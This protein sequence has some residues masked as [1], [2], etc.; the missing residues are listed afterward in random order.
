MRFSYPIPKTDDDFEHLCCQLL[1]R[2][3]NRPQLQRYAHRGEEQDGVDIYDPLQTK[4]IRAAQCKLHD[5]GKTI[6]PKEI[7]EEVDKAKNHTPSIEHYT[8]LTTAKKSKQA[9]RKVAEINQL[10]QQEGLFTVEVL[11]WDQIEALLDQYPDVRDPIYNTVSG[12]TVTLF[13]QQFAALRVAIEVS[14]QPSSDAL[15]AELD[16][17]KAEV[18]RYEL[19]VAQRLAKR[20]EER[21][22][23]KLSPRQR[24][25]LL[26]LQASIFL[27]EGELERAGTLLLQA[28]QHQPQEE[29]AQVN[30]AL[31][32]EL[33]GDSERAHSLAITLRQ[34][35]PH[36]S[37]A[38]AVW[39]RTAPGTVGSA[40]LEAE[41]AQFAD[42]ECDVAL[43]LSI[44]SLNRGDV[45][46]AERHARRAT[47]L[48]PEVP[49]TWLMLG[50]S[51]HVRGFKEVRAEQRLQLLRQ[52]EAHYSKAVELAQAQGSAH[53]EAA[54]QLNRGIVRDL[55]GDSN[56]EEDFRAARRL[57]PQDASAMRKH[58]L[59]LANLGQMDQAVAEAR[60]ALT[61]EPDNESS[62][63]LA[64]MLWDRKQG[65]D[66]QQALDLC[67]K[68]ARGMGTARFDEALEMA[69][70]GLSE[71]KRWDEARVLLDSLAKGRVSE[72]ARNTFLAQLSLAQD[73]RAGAE[74][75][76]RVAHA[77]VGE[78]TGAADL[79]RLS[80]LL[81]RL[82]LYTLALPLLQ[83]ITQPGRFDSDTQ[84]LLDCANHLH[85]HRVILDVCRALR[86]AG[87]RD[88]RLLDNE[89]DI[90]QLYDR[91]AAI[92]VLLS[93]LA[94][95][96]D[97]RL[98][99]MRLSLLGLQSER[100]D[101]VT[102]DPDRLPRV[103]EAPPSTVGKAVI[104]LLQHTGH[105]S[106][107]LRYAYA[108]L[109]RNLSDPDA[110]LLYCNL[111]LL[112]EQD[113]LPI[114]SASTVQPGMAVAY[115]EKGDSQ[116]HW[117]VLEE[118]EHDLLHDELSPNHARVQQML[119]KRPGDT[120]SLSM[121]GIQ[122]RTAE[123]VAILSKY[124]Y[125]F[126]DSMNQFQVRFPTREDLQQVRLATEGSE[127]N[128]QLDPTPI[129]ASLDRRRERVQQAL[130]VFHRQPTPVHLLA[131]SVGRHIF[132][133][134]NSLTRNPNAGVRWCCLGNVN[135][136]EEALGALRD[137]RSVVLD[138]TAL[139]T[140]W[141]LNLFDLLRRWG[142]R[143]FCVSQTTLDKVRD[144]IE[145]ETRPGTRRQIATDDHGRYVF[146]EVPD[147]AL[148][149][150]VEAHQRLGAFIRE[151]CMLPVPELA[152]LDP[153]RR[154]QLVELFDRDGLESITLAARDGH[155]LWTD[156]LTLAVIAREDFGSPRRAWTQVVLQAAVEEGV[157]QQTEFD[158]YSAHLIGLGYSFTWCSPAIVLQAGSIA[159]WNCE[160]W[161]LRQ[162]IRYFRLENIHPQMKLQMA[163]HSIVAMFRAVSSP[164]SRQV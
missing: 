27:G 6:P 56:A 17:I 29:K 138:L 117:V 20:F 21:H 11:T 22:G 96:P 106:E 109:R 111:I 129:F 113:G 38:A 4:P 68:A 154:E 87:E 80:R 146:S 89:V 92:E 33:T 45:N 142:S 44:C 53:I 63:L 39:V 94:R 14:T 30:E 155:L 145:S 83:R 26:S 49:Q 28:K 150:Y 73:D 88:R 95:H 74:S 123:V 71:F 128:E 136:R 35:F 51:V 12:Q 65:N 32:Y 121:A 76:A 104:G 72:V 85:N 61:A 91:P 144:I 132:E 152:N 158:G 67:L 114:N 98:A 159:N 7:Q 149:P 48:E 112:R 107:A 57:A 37:A 78:E 60:A 133:T 64:A 162:V 157:L 81:G 75:L 103:D 8:I 23:D 55:L 31:G 77:A 135:E 102:S 110:H 59:Y 62:V 105:C 36:S 127:D 131:S 124:V 143:P 161:P 160:A 16:A 153:E 18:E 42:K 15:D 52:A 90:L 40:E 125:R 54:A 119:G 148:R 84:M 164:F 25:R 13:T 70:L 141:R 43:A 100:A 118:K 108:L 97:D 99:R 116:D 24:W 46:R 163:A 69:I 126:Q 134:L 2:H 5:Y 19:R 47:E 79:R 86:E 147:E 120:F 10:H 130:S 66:R 137:C 34:T 3:W 9:D 151:C 50:Q 139:Y 115:R 93:H 58:A 140:V 156:D 1:K 101:L 122:E 82:G 41:V